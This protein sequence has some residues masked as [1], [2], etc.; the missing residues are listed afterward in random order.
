MQHVLDLA[1]V[2]SLSS[3]CCRTT[4]KGIVLADYNNDGTLDLW[5]GNIRGG[6]DLFIN[7]GMVE[8]S[9]DGSPD[10]LTATQDIVAGDYNND[11]WLDSFTPG[12][13]MINPPFGPK[14]T[15]IMY[16]NVTPDSTLEN[17][18]WIKINLEGAKNT[19]TND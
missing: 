9:R 17:Y 1:P 18:N 4:A 6:D 5:A 14:Y 16:K 8:W 3:C 15:S 19:I 7:D 11:G 10:Y 12:L 13:E 2:T